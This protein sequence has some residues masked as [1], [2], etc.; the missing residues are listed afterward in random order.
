MDEDGCMSITPPL[1]SIDYQA[2]VVGSAYGSLTNAAFRLTPDG[3]M[4]HSIRQP[5]AI[6]LARDI[7]NPLGVWRSDALDAVHEV[8]EWAY[9]HSSLVLALFKECKSSIRAYTWERLGN[10]WAITRV[11]G[12]WGVTAPLGKQH[13]LSSL[14][15]ESV[16][17]YRNRGSLMVEL[18]LLEFGEEVVNISV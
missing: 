12:A 8:E 10:D 13:Q 1:E 16:N 15:L 7:I 11:G 18:G 4:R 17:D 5:E 2:L 6:L 3:V 9:L 14:V